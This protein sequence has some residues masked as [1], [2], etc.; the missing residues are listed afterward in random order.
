MQYCAKVMQTNFDEFH[1]I[2]RVFVKIL[3]RVLALFQQKG[4]II[5]LQYLITGNNRADSSPV[6]SCETIMRDDWGRVR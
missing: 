2:V 5:L 3:R 1:S 6:V 4:D